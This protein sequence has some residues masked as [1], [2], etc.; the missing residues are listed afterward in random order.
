MTKLQGIRAV[1]TGGGTGIGRAI[2]KT[3]ALAGA[4]VAVTGRKLES[5]EET[6][7]EIHHDSG[8]ASAYRLDV[9]D[10]AAVAETFARISRDLGGIDCLVNN[11]GAGGP[12]ALSQPGEDRWREILS[13]N[14]DGMFFC[15]R[16][17]LRP[18]RDGGRVIN[19]SSVLG[20][21]GVPGYTAYCT[22]KHGVIGFTRALALEVAPRKITVN[23]VCPGW[24]DTEMART[25]LDLLA[26]G[27]GVAFE[28]AKKTAL[29]QV[30]L[31]R[32]VTPEEVAGLC[33]FL[34]SDAAAAM[35]GT[36]ISI[37]GGSAM[38]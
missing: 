32:M 38:M 34:A 36:A 29:A 31:G 27:M 1:V 4:T 22:S 12:N 28:E 8:M 7:R 25:G 13:V 17:A 3:F 10:P 14:L 9:T 15:T 26:Q 5:L 33:A 18:M 16:E 35:T 2:A 19:I 20:K 37:C 6:V 11:A 30:P 24:T 23:A 21:F